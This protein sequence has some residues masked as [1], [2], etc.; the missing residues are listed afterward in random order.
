MCV[1]HLIDRYNF[2]YAREW[3]YDENTFDVLK[4][5]KEKSTN[6]AI[7][8]KTNWLFYPSFYFYSYTGKTPWLDLQGYD[9]SI[10]LNTKAEYYYI[11]SEDYKIL[12][13]KFEVI[14][15][16]T[17]DRWLVKRKL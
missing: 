7:V 1:F 17:N 6:K 10:D 9:K 5:L 4:Y 11:L 14:Y 16:V 8:L 15:K 2:K 13:P 3:W 12:G